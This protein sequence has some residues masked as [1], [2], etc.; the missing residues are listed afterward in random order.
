[1]LTALESITPTELQDYVNYLADDQRE[2]REAGTRGGRQAGDYLGDQLRHLGL[3]P[4]G[5]D[6]TFYQPF[7]PNFRNVLA[8]VEGSDP[9]LKHQYIV[10]CAH[11]DHIGYGQKRNSLGAVGQIHNGADDNAS[12]TA[13]LLEVA[14]ALTLLPEPPRRSI[15]IAFWD[16]EE[17]GLLGST[18]W[19]NHPTVP[20]DEIGLLVNM[21]MIGR[22]RHDRLLLMG[23]RT[24]YGL[25]RI[26]CENNLEPDLLL[27]FPTALRANADHYPFASHSIPSLTLHTDLHEDYHRPSDHAERVNPQGMRQVTQLLLRFVYHTANRDELP[28]F[29]EAARKETDEK[30]SLLPP[31]PLPARLGASWST[32]QSEGP[33]VQLKAVQTQSAAE[34]AGLKPGDRIIAMAGQPVDSGEELIQA[35]MTSDRNTQAVVVRAGHEEPIEITVQ[36]DG[37]PLRLGATWHVDDAEPGT[38]ILDHVVPGSP[39]ERAGLQVDDRIY[40]VAGRDFSDEVQFATL[41]RTLPSP[42]ELLIERSGR[43]RRSLLHLAPPPPH[44]AG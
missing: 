20:L 15:V 35:V 33:G 12:G 44:R 11:Y 21:D 31:A 9:Q 18:H 26:I 3:S 7:A 37:Q 5:V 8:V 22:L 2:G 28:R 16:A 13:G 34:R 19:A 6:G 27:E 39:A 24:G 1:L 30:A 29:R 32:P 23:S 10:L 14:Q 4:A 36:L 43:L 38:V 40:Q 41:I 17:K 25:R 42:V